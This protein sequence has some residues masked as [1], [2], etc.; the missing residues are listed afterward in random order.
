[1]NENCWEIKKCGRQPGGPLVLNLGICPAALESSLEG[2]HG[3]V[4][5]GRACWIVTGTLCN[6]K[7]QGTFN[8]KKER[9]VSCDFY[10]LVKEEEGPNFQVSDELMKK[11]ECYP[12]C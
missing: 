6:M 4:K 7:I 5:C 11:L 3:G 12:L 1:M 2:V 10:I 8:E 9:C